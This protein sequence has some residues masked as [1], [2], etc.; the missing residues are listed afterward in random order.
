MP[1]SVARYSPVIPNP[2]MILLRLMVLR[3]FVLASLTV[4]TLIFS[5][6][7]TSHWVALTLLGLSTVAS[8]AAYFLYIYKQR[9]ITETVLIFQMVWDIA[10]VLLVL[11]TAGRSTNPF[12]YYLL[13][14]TAISASIFRERVVWSFCSVSIGAYSLF[15]YFDTS[16]HMA[17]LSSDFRLHL[18]GMWINFVG[19]AILISFFIA[20]ITASLRE[21]EAALGK[22]REDMLKKERLLGLGTLAASTVHNLGTPLSTIT[23]AAGEIAQSHKDLQTQ[24]YV[25]TIRGQIDRCKSAMAKLRLMAGPAA[26]TSHYS[27][28]MLFSEVEEY[29]QLNCASP[30]PVFNTSHVKDKEAP[31][32][33]GGI[34][35]VHALINLVDNAVR[36]AQTKVIV[37][38]KSHREII[39]I[40]IEDDGTGVDPQILESLGNAV[41]DSET[42]LGIGFLLANSTVE[43]FGGH[44]HV[45]NTDAGNHRTCTLITVTLP[46]V[47]GAQHGGKGE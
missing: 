27:I 3:A 17:H 38:G 31:C 13:V 4:Y 2:S 1:N 45:T 26:D 39:E 9:A 12:I 5:Q 8:L 36:S 19:S 43:Q 21:K 11:Y 40:H 44:V 46:R 29:F 25:D 41:T 23:L 34:L 35:L 22:A 32:L 7:P 16:A 42:G 15:M 33:T 6:S 28:D 14:I 37:S 30:M 24:A 47:T 10:V 20:R 18:F